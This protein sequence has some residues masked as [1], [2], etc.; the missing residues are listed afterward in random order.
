MGK[1][2]FKILLQASQWQLVWIC[3]KIF[4]FSLRSYCSFCCQF[5]WDCFL[6]LIFL[7]SSSLHTCWTPVYWTMQQ[8]CLCFG[9]LL[10]LWKWN[11]ISVTWSQLTLS[12]REKCK[13]KSAFVFLAFG[14]EKVM[15][16][17]GFHKGKLHCST[18][19]ASSEMLASLSSSLH[20]TAIIKKMWVHSSKNKFPTRW[21]VGTR[22][23]LLRDTYF[24]TYT[25]VLWNSHVDPDLFPGQDFS[26]DLTT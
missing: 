9:V 18:C 19:T 1:F 4:Q 23:F 26:C 15:P 10:Y 25:D 3:R 13:K 6:Q 21:S 8:E 5:S 22:V 14:L 17:L 11:D 20:G 16:I 7:S 2:P 12:S 24:L